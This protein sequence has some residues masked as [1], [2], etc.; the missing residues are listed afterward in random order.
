MKNQLKTTKSKR[1]IYETAFIIGVIALVS[2]LPY[3][4]DFDFFKGME[5]FSGFSSL[6]IGIW[7]VSLFILALSG[8]IFAFLGHKNRKYRWIMLAPIIMLAYQLLIY[9][10]DA[11]KT[12]T[13]DFNV[14]VTFNFVL[15]IF[16]SGIYIYGLYNRSK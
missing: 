7:V 4:H 3:I 8:W 13:N 11:R 14:K 5:G 2:F 9:L 15:L 6:R 16:L 12:Q 10:F 1:R